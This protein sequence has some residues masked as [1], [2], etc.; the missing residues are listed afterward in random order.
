MADLL[1][2]GKLSDAVCPEPGLSGANTRK[3][4]GGAG[5]GRTVRRLPDHASAE[6]HSE[7]RRSGFC[8][9]E[10]RLFRPRQLSRL[11]LQPPGKTAPSLVVGT[12]S[13]LWLRERL[14]LCWRLRARLSNLRQTAAVTPTGTT[15][16]G[17]RAQA[18]VSAGADRTAAEFAPEKGTAGRDRLELPTLLRHDLPSHLV[19]NEDHRRAAT[20]F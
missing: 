1:A 15:K 9:R 5:A 14:G 18:A 3:S 17:V 13:R 8:E 4:G 12:R 10:E 16:T 2:L 11:R 20:L 19:C 7:P 6:V